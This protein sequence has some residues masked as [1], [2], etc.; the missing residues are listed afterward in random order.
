[1]TSEPQR[2]PVTPPVML[3]VDEVTVLLGLLGVLCDEHVDDDVAGVAGRTAA[4]LRELLGPATPP[5]R[6]SA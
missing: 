1:M 4:R 3:T 2:R 6:P 5:D